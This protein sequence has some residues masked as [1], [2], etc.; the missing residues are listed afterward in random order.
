MQTEI[1]ELNEVDYALDITVPADEIQAQ[2]T[3]AL[4]KERGQISLKGFRPGKVPMGVVR[5]MVGKQVAVQVAEE[6]IGEAYRTAVV[7]NESVEPIGHPRLVDMDFEVDDP[8]AELKAEVRF[9]VKPEFELAEMEGVPVTRL[10]RTFTDEDIEADLQRRLD[11]AAELVDEDESAELTEGHVATVDIQP[12]DDE[13]EPTGPVQREAQIVLANPDLREELKN[14]LLGQTAGAEVRVDFP[15]EDEAEEEGIVDRYRVTVQKVQRRDVPEMTDE[16]VKE[17]TN[18]KTDTVDGLRE[19]ARAELENSWERRSRQQMESKMVEAFV[20]AH[21]FAVPESLTEAAL[22]AMVDD[23]RQRQ[24]DQALPVGFDTASYREQNRA[25][26]E[27]QVRWLL[28][29]D[30][31]VEEENLE[32]TNDDFETEF[33]RIAGEDGDVDMMRQFF[34]QNG[35]ML[36]QMGDHLLNQRVFDSLSKRFDIVEKTRDDLEKEAEARKAE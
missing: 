17:H 22:D 27:N 14:A 7:E 4:K 13:G 25:Q 12:V 31:L 35:Q 30:K 9:G 19:E 10:V 1:R 26:A 2:I 18:G 24:P 20:E 15:Q 6:A 11:M 23:L 28:V 34:T 21:P 5:K 36:Q 29:K 33:A 3:S 8:Q 16:W 32:V